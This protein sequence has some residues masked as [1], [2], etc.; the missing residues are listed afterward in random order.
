MSLPSPRRVLLTL[1]LAA[2]AAGLTG[3]QQVQV[4]RSSPASAN[5]DAQRGNTAL[6]A[7]DAGLLQDSLRQQGGV[8][9]VHIDA[10]PTSAGDVDTKSSQA[11]IAGRGRFTAITVAMTA[12]AQGTIEAFSSRGSQ[13]EELYCQEVVQALAQAGYVHLENIHVEIY[14]NG[15]HHST[16]SWASSTGFVFKVLDGRP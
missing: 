13:T 10:T 2:L 5:F 3:C 1:G 6:T 15:S 11:V 12:S 4:I 16:L 7:F 9:T 8:W 14:Y